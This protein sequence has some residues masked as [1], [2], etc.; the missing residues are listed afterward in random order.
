[1]DK[2][3]LDQDKLC[4]RSCVVRDYKIGTDSVARIN[5]PKKPNVL[6]FGYK[7]DSPRSYDMR[8][9]KAFKKVNKEYLEMTLMSL[10]G[11]VGGTLGMFVGFSLN[12]MLDSSDWFWKGT[13]KLMASLRQ[14]IVKIDKKTNQPDNEEKTEQQA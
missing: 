9:E 14:K 13:F 5:G 11:S 10:I 12:G 4:K 6:V 1:M 8:S 7:F 3:K 2:L